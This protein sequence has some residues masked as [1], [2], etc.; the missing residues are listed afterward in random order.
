M[1]TNVRLT[2]NWARQACRLFLPG[3]FSLAISVMAQP[4]NYSCS[5]VPLPAGTSAAGLSDNGGNN[6]QG[7]NTCYVIGNFYSPYLTL[8][9]KAYAWSVGCPPLP[10]DIQESVLW[11]NAG[12]ATQLLPLNNDPHDVYDT[13]MGAALATATATIRVGRTVL[14]YLKPP[15][16]QNTLAFHA[17]EW[18]PNGAGGYA[19]LDL[20]PTSIYFTSTAYG[21][22]HRSDNSMLILGDGA[23]LGARGFLPSVPLIWTIAAAPNPG[24]AFAGPAALA[25][26]VAG[27]SSDVLAGSK[28]SDMTT[29]VGQGSATL[30]NY[31]STC[32]VIWQ[33]G[34]ALNLNDPANLNAPAPFALPASGRNN[35]NCGGAAYAVAAFTDPNDATKTDDIV[36]GTVKRVTVA[37]RLSRFQDQAFI[38]TSAPGGGSPFTAV[39]LN[40]ILGGLDSIANGVNA[41]ETVV[42]DVR[43]STGWAGFIATY[44]GAAWTG[45]VATADSASYSQN[46]LKAPGRNVASWKITS[47]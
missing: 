12:T 19:A 35:S 38:W 27:R 40:T 24:D 33:G 9:Q 25:Q 2:S 5:I 47:I 31:A 36:V 6:T 42:G 30:N 22:V 45:F 23:N 26:L 39:N 16:P 15:D 3:G 11:P 28:R 18:K 14:H 44:D 46:G 13:G 37:N 41:G 32:A 29:V 20:D 4:A 10:V 1:K 43:L 8:S 34:G 17:T 7:N 21:M